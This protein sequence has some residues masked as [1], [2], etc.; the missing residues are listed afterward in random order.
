VTADLTTTEYRDR[1]TSNGAAAAAGFSTFITFYHISHRKR[2]ILGGFSWEK[3]RIVAQSAVEGDK[4][5][6]TI[7]SA[8]TGSGSG[9]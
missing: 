3:Q 4:S 7:A 8:A 6:S 2:R 1:W 5:D 9:S